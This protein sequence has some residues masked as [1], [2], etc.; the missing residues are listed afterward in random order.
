MTSD[1]AEAHHRRL[2]RMY[3]GAPINQWYRPRLSISHGATELVLPLRPEFHHAAGATH[4][5]VYFKVL[6]DATFFAA[7]SIVEDVFVLTARF[8]IDF[9]RPVV[10]GDIRGVANVTGEADR[11]IHAEGELFDETG[12]VIAKGRGR[13]PRSKSLLA[14]ALGYL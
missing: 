14:P 8:E 6:D 4:G 11:R 2:E 12:Q 7:A 9:L 3:A 5:S 10:S 1:E 13:C